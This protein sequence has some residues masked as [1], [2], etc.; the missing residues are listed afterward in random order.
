MIHTKIIII[1]IIKYEL[2]FQL[3]LNI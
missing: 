1:I 3:Y 2:N